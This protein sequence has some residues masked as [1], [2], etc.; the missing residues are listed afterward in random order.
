MQKW[1]LVLGVLLGLVT[2][3]LLN[4]YMS[5]VESSTQAV[6]FL[7][8]KPG[9]AVSAGDVIDEEMLVQEL[10]PKRFEDLA[11][12]VMRDDSPTREFLRDRPVNADLAAGAPLLFTYF[13]DTDA[14]RFAAKINP[15][16]RAMA[17][18]VEPASAVGYLIE[19][20]SLVDVLGTFTVPE[21]RFEGFAS[22]AGLVSRTV[23]QGVRVLAVDRAASRRAF[24]DLQDAGFS[25]VTLEVT[26]Q[27]AET[28]TAAVDQ[29]KR[30]LT[31]TLRNPDDLDAVALS[32]LECS[33][34]QEREHVPAD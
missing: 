13:R 15:G 2:V 17:I 5:Q 31:L 1:L 7:R 16:Y 29:V 21:D 12:L 32:T 4:V 28:L 33:P 19:P 10:L 30:A 22:Q 9:V 3:V 6:A 26:P 18:R 34:R 25:S 20:G 24:L 11:D 23:L 8:L 14:D 27:Q